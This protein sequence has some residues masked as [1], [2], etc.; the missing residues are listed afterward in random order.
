MF[1][2]CIS[3]HRLDGV[4]TNSESARR[5]STPLVGCVERRVT[6]QLD[7]RPVDVSLV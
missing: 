1:V 4:V 2:C 3:S 7:D 5:V 6:G